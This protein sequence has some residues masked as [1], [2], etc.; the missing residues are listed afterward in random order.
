MTGSPQPP[1]PPDAPSLASPHRFI[2]DAATVPAPA[3]ETHTA[4]GFAVASTTRPDTSQSIE[5]IGNHEARRRWGHERGK[6]TDGFAKY[7]L[8]P[9]PYASVSYVRLLSTAADGLRFATTSH[10]SPLAPIS[11][12]ALTAFDQTVIASPRVQTQNI[13]FCDSDSAGPHLT[14]QERS[15]GHVVLQVSR[16]TMSEASISDCNLVKSHLRFNKDLVGTPL[17]RRMQQGDTTSRLVYHFYACDPQESGIRRLPVLFPIS[18]LIS[19]DP[20]DERAAQTSFVGI[21]MPSQRQIHC[22]DRLWKQSAPSLV[23][24]YE[25][26]YDLSSLIIATVPTERVNLLD[27]LDSII[28]ATAAEKDTMRVEISEFNNPVGGLT[29]QEDKVQRAASSDCSLHQPWQPGAPASFASTVN[30]STYAPNFL[31]PSFGAP[32]ISALDISEGLAAAGISL[33]AAAAITFRIYR[34]RLH[35]PGI[36]IQGP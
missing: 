14:L 21:T 6:L 26:L 24:R 13:W 32:R 31:I 8:K 27:R 3:D 20:L 5:R 35:P 16:H 7:R 12:R 34:A 2:F 28:N 10:L 15:D 25:F 22:V 11:R 23:G 36:G 1:S 29:R 4:F 33:F 17:L 18:S 30:V 19:V 9:A